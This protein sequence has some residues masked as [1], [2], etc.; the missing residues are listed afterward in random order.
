MARNATGV[1]NNTPLKW[2]VA[3]KVLKD[4]LRAIARILFRAVRYSVVPHSGLPV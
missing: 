3:F 1:Y 4:L 2:P